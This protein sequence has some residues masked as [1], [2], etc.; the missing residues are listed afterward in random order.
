MWVV[1]LEL[2]YSDV[3]K[4]TVAWIESFSTT[5]YKNGG[6]RQKVRLCSTFVSGLHHLPP[7]MK[8]QHGPNEEK[9]FTG[10]KIVPHLRACDVT[11][12]VG[13]DTN[14]LNVRF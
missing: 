12:V 2:Y 6:A 9:N 8:N 1:S 7:Q 4:T 5:K 11:R 14:N 3:G 10:N 13:L